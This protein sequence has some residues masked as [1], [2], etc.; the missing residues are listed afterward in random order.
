MK[1]MYYAVV[2]MFGALFGI[3]EQ[4]ERR[5]DDLAKQLP[6]KWRTNS[7]G[8]EFVAIS[9]TSV[10]ACKWETRV[11]DYTVFAQE[12]KT[13]WPKT[14]FAQG[15]EHPAVNVSWSNAQ[16][17]CLWLT[18]RETKLGLL[19]VGEKYRLPTDTEWSRAIGLGAEEGEDPRDRGGKYSEIYPWGQG[20]PPP[21][22]TGNYRG[23]ETLVTTRDTNE[24]IKGYRDNFKWTA[25]VGSFKPNKFGLYDI[26]GNA[27]EW[28]ED[29]ADKFSS[30]RVVRGSFWG[31][32]DHTRLLSS[33]RYDQEPDFCGM[34]VYGF[35]CV[36]DVRKMIPLD[37]KTLAPLQVKKQFPP[38]YAE[39]E[40]ETEKDAL[41]HK[42][43][44]IKSLA[45]PDPEKR[46]QAAAGLAQANCKEAIPQLGVLAV[47]DPDRNVRYSAITA[48]AVTKN[49]SIMPYMLK[50]LENN[51]DFRNPRDFLEGIHFVAES[52]ADFHRKEGVAA[53]VQLLECSNES[54]QVTAF[55]EL[56]T[57]TKLDFGDFDK[58]ENGRFFRDSSKMK[59]VFAH[60]K[61]WWLKEGGKFVFPKE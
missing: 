7:L 53:L 47:S 57:I 25:P 51:H 40:A 39:L 50:V 20:W 22:G 3:A 58:I 60:W 16:A 2:F 1:L 46:A 4:A 29:L 41:R 32:W 35:R 33:Y 55:C 54:H 23:E 26:S 38:S 31:E 19:K 48:L 27:A 36:L 37:V 30:R 14:A 10:M 8:M 9:G 17:F 24:V 18:A 34:D 13:D 21:P 12:T 61:N 43:E 44:Y 28:C 11:K 56:K 49:P 15:Q 42:D 59:E 52:L 5:D 6:S 45:D